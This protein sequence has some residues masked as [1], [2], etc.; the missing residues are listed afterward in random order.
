MQTAQDLTLLDGGVEAFPRMVLAIEQAR[1]TVQLEMYL[2][3][4]DAT[5][6][7]FVAALSAAAARGVAVRVSLD[8]WGSSQDAREIE[9]E[10]VAA[11]CTV[12]IQA[13]R[14]WFLRRALARNHRK[15]LLV[16]E[17]VA[18]VG[19]I[20][21]GD[22]YGA[23]GAVAGWADLAVEIRSEACARLAR[24]LRRERIPEAPAAIRIRLANRGGGWRLRRRYLEAFRGARKSIHLA[25]GYF[26]PNRQIL[27]A[28]IHAVRRGVEVA[29]LLPEHSDVPFAK[30]AMRYVY[31]PLLAGGVRIWEW[32]LSVLHAK[33]AVIDGRK[34]LV[35][36]FNLEPLSLISMEA[37]VEADDE[38]AAAQGGRW[39]REHFALASAVDPGDIA[40]AGPRWWPRSLFA[41]LLG[42]MRH[43]LERVLVRN[44]E[45]LGRGL[46]KRF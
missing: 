28:L 38:G 17:R 2:F 21:V 22:E 44:R 9:A 35:G 7:C 42:W 15:L 45:R 13:W 46:R 43:S 12:S 25:Q 5:G 32:H 11:G 33:A 34:L 40:G 4:L 26:L 36:S 39:M 18:F 8:G 29:V 16:D 1:K 37:L 19:G 31:A 30:L 41:T 24:E 27:R 3:R 14:W 10:L 6:R 20:N 23:P